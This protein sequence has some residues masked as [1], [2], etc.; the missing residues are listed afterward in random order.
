MIVLIQ[1]IILLKNIKLKIYLVLERME[2]INYFTK[3]STVIKIF[4][5]KNSKKAFVSFGT[6]YKSK[7]SGNIHYKTFLQRQL[8]D[9]LHEDKNY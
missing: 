3:Y 9:Y 2:I 5:N 4:K 8:I 7:K 6:F 1:I